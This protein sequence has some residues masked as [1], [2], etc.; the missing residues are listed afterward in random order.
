MKL[1]H[2]FENFVT[3][4]AWTNIAC[5]SYIKL[6]NINLV[7][8]INLYINNF[9][10]H[11]HYEDVLKIFLIYRFSPFLINPPQ[12]VSV[13]LYCVCLFVCGNVGKNLLRLLFMAWWADNTPRVNYSSFLSSKCWRKISQCVLG[14]TAKAVT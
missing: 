7:F 12:N 1:L 3:I 10:L 6:F 14:T 8:K 5:L 13:Y 9:P 2:I 4:Y 11:Q